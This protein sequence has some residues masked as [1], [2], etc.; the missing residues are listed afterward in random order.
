MSNARTCKP[1]RAHSVS[2]QPCNCG[3]GHFYIELLDACGRAF[4]QAWF[5]RDDLLRTAESMRSVAE[6]PVGLRVTH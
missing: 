1:K 3:C 6:E 4:A 2:W 5:G